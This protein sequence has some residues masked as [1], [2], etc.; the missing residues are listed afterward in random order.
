M[1]LC[2]CSSTLLVQLLHADTLYKGVEDVSPPP[3]I[4]ESGIERHING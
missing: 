4:E 3:S 1:P 2:V